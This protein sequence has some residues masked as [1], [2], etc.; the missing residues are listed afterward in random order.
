MLVNVCRRTRTSVNQ[1]WKSKSSA[2]LNASDKVEGLANFQ[3][4]SCPYIAGASGILP[5]SRPQILGPKLFCWG[6]SPHLYRRLRN[7]SE[8]NRAIEPPPEPL[9]YN[10]LNDD[11]SR[12]SGVVFGTLKK[13]HAESGSKRY[14]TQ[15]TAAIPTNPYEHFAPDTT[16]ILGD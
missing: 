8:R 1:S 12:P 6:R 14:S 10:M 4:P 3:V 13:N 7:K 11:L 5:G 16:S 9:S 2:F 15:T